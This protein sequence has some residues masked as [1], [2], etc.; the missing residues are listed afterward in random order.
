MAVTGK[1]IVKAPLRQNYRRVND[2]LETTIAMWENLYFLEI[3][4]NLVIVLV[5]NEF[6]LK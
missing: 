1:A 5:T 3:G 2:P 6:E 4:K